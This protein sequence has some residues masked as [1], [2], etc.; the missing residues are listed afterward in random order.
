[1]QLTKSELFKAAHADV[2][3]AMAEQLHKHPSACKSYKQLFAI[4]LEGVYINE[5]RKLYAPVEQPKFMF[6]RGM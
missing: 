5:A 1:M 4:C 6:L 3:R 2:K